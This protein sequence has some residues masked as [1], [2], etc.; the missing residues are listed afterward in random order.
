[1]DLPF[2][3]LGSSLDESFNARK[4][5]ANESPE[6]KRAQATCKAVKV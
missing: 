6:V 1:M 5:I 3:E 4:P 2:Q